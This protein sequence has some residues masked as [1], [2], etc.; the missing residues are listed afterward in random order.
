MRNVTAIATLLTAALGS[1]CMTEPGTGPGTEVEVGT[2]EQALTECLPQPSYN[3]IAVPAAKSW[4]GLPATPWGARVII[5]SAGQGKWTAYA[6]DITG[7]KIAWVRTGTGNL[8]SAT[9]TMGLAGIGYLL[10]PPPRPN[11]PPGTELL[12]V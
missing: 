8:S 3:Y 1:G 10:R 5:A 2:T 4:T 11:P 6:V 7:K 9:D 12:K